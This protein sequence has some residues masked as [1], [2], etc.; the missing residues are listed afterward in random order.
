MSRELSLEEGSQDHWRLGTGV[1]NQPRLPP[2]FPSVLST[3]MSP[4]L[5]MR[6]LSLERSCNLPQ[7]SGRAGGAVCALLCSPASVEH[8]GQVT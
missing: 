4:I 3:R 7:I 6:K 1:W 5:K 2:P 8:S